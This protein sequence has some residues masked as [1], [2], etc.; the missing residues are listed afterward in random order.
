MATIY[1]Y[2]KRY[3]VIEVLLTGLLSVG[4]IIVCPIAAF[5]G[6]IPPA[7]WMLTVA[8]IYQAWNTFVAI[9]NPETVSLDDE[10]ISFSAWGRTDRYELS[11]LTQFRVREFPS[12]GKMYLRINDHNLF[13]GRYWLQTRLMEGSNG[14][15]GSKLFHDVIDLEYRLHPDTIKAQARRVNTE[16][17]EAERK[18]KA[19]AGENVEEKAATPSRRH[20]RKKH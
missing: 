9:A 11:E 5:N 6:F 1:T 3:F 14:E 17:I 16:Y 7:M 2:I 19:E 4:A 15:P 13:H 18:R 12:A 8:A 10:S 20:R